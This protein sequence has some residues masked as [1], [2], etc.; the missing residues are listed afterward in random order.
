MMLYERSLLKKQ[1][2][3]LSVNSSQQ[4]IKRIVHQNLKLNEKKKKR[5]HNIRINQELKKIFENQTS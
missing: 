2:S 4:Q 1:R 3:T 5:N